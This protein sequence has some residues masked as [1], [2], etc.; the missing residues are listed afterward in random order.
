MWV[1]LLG[2]TAALH[3]L[4]G[5]HGQTAQ[6]RRMPSARECKE[7]GRVVPVVNTKRC[8]GKQD[9]VEVCPYGVFTVRELTDA[10][11]AALGWLTRFKVLVHGGKQAFVEQPE[12]CHAC[13]LCV[14]ACPEKAITLRGVG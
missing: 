8:E 13:G 14:Q 3:F 10:E 5:Q 7:T 6:T 12:Q 9:C 2:A 11:R 4:A 1:L